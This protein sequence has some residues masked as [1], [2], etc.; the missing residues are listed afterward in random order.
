MTNELVFVNYT[1]ETFTATASGALATYIYECCRAASA[2]G[3]EPWVISRSASQPAF[4]WPRLRL[5]AYP[6]RPSGRLGT[7][8]TRVQ[9]KSTGLPKLGQ[10]AWAKRV[11][12]AVLD[13]AGPDCTVV[14]QNDPEVAVYL[15]A[16]LPRARI[17]LLFQNQL[18]AREP[19]RT[20]VS[21]SV[22]Q[23]VAISDFT[24]AWI[25][26]HYRVPRTKIATLYPG[27][28]ADVIRPPA[29]R[30]GVPVI[31]FVGR[32]GIEK[33][34]DTVLKAAI[35]LAGRTTQFAVQIVG[36]N[37]WDRYDEDAYQRELNAL[38]AAL[39]RRGVRVTRPGH[40]GRETL[41]GWLQRSSIHVVPS[42]WDE[43][44]GLTTLEGMAAGNAVVASRTGGTPEVVGGGGQLFE[45]DDVAGLARLLESLVIDETARAE[46][47]RR[48]RA[49]AESLTWTRTYRQ[50]RALAQPAAAERVE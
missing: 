28:A 19:F 31:G 5:L 12:R 47:G 34:P 22:D 24:A 38:A 41:P 46:W 7:Q 21:Q 37:H 50:L 25:G 18:P 33:A 48:A 17:V 8:L 35:A 4:D 14:L 16:A 15:R 27:V 44:F 40:V 45:R 36:S 23:V 43:P 6:R 13:A 11:A 49:R 10:R 1:D 32:T 42:R 39:E 26:E 30:S 9:R 3:D 2:L 20:R 29:A